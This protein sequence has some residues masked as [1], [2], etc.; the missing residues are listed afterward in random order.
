MIEGNELAGQWYV[1]LLTEDGT[2]AGG[3]HHTIL[4]ATTADP[5]KSELLIDDEGHYG[6]FVVKCPMDIPNRT[7]TG[8]SDSLENLGGGAK[9]FVTSGKVLEGVGRSK[10]G[11]EVDSIYMMI[12]YG[13]DSTATVYE[14][15]GH[16]RTGFGDDDY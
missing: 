15:S 8:G 14:L 7:F 6:G 3:G 13:D 11:V 10:T 1:R 5:S 9:M 12:Q 4:T 16:R 2:D